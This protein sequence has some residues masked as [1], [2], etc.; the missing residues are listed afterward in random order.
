MASRGSNPST[1]KVHKSSGFS[2]HRVDCTECNA[3]ND[4]T[5]SHTKSTHFF[6]ELRT[7]F[8]FCETGFQCPVFVGPRWYD[9]AVILSGSVARGREARFVVGIVE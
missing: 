4:C 6:A 2:Q 1:A 5:Q 9:V 8:F 3:D 7:L